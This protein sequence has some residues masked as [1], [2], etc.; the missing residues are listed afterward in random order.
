MEMQNLVNMGPIE[1]L[2][3]IQLPS[4]KFGYVG[5][6]PVE[7]GYIDPTPEKL[8]AAKHGARFGPKRRIFETRDDAAQF[9]V[10]HGYSVN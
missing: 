4:G 3:I 6:V 2:H 5:Q 10:D 9:A 1:T 8:A 7:I